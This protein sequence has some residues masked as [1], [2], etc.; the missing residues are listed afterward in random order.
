ML[1]ASLL[2]GVNLI[3]KTLLTT[4]SEAVTNMLVA[5]TTTQVGT[6]RSILASVECSASS[7]LVEGSSSLLLKLQ[8]AGENPT[9]MANSGPALDGLTTLSLVQLTTTMAG[10]LQ[11]IA[12]LV[13]HSVLAMDLSELQLL[14]ASRTTSTLSGAALPLETKLLQAVATTMQ[15]GTEQS[16]RASLDNAETFHSKT[17]WLM[18]YSLNLFPKNS[19]LPIL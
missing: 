16:T 7:I 10:L 15:L 1:R 9:T 19:T 8:Q 11:P 6:T 14:A 5:Q 18:T 4:A 13:L 3:T 12:A 2:H 17:R